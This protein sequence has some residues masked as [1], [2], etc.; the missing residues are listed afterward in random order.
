MKPRRPGFGRSRS[1]RR[2][3]KG[4]SSWVSRAE[5]SFRLMKTKKPANAGFFCGRLSRSFALETVREQVLYDR[6][7]REVVERV[8]LGEA[9]RSECLRGQCCNVRVERKYADAARDFNRTA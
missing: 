3:S 7:L 4:T 9:E 8:H 5:P 2:G 6:R 1:S